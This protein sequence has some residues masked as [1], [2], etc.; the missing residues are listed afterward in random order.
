[1]SLL[2][3]LTAFFAGLGT[4]QI[5]LHDQANQFEQRNDAE[6]KELLKELKL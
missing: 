1:M 3:K 5:L 4:M 2:Q 6:I